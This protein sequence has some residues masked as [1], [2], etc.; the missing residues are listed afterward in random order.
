ML[1]EETARLADSFFSGNEFLDGFL[2]SKDA[3]NDG[4]GKTFVWVDEKR[5]EI[6][7]YYN[8]GVGYIDTYDG[9]DKYKVGGSVHLNFFALNRLYR[10]VVVQ[11]KNDGTKIR[12]SDQL[13]ADFMSKVYKLREEFIGFS[14]VTLAATDEGIS[15]YR[16]NLFEELDADLHFSLKDDEIGCKPMYLALDREDMY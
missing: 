12:V 10:G 9:D 6:I 3:F 13:F 14:F 15:L 1:S 7:G 4:I 2:K 8:L 16:R 11:I 5:T